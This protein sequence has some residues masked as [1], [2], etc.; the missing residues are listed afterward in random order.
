MTH[1]RHY[2]QF[3]AEN[4]SLFTEISR[5]NFLRV[6]ASTGLL[7]ATSGVTYAAGEALLLAVNSN[8]LRPQRV[9][10]AVEVAGQMKMNPTGREVKYLPMSVTAEQLF[11]QRRLPELK[12]SKA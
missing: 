3:V 2:K 7:A 6:S 1:L 4:V 11:L 8:E 9:K 12:D 10:I 5:R